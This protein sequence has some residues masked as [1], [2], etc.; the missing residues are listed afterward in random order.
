MPPRP[1]CVSVLYISKMLSA[2]LGFESRL[3]FF[4]SEEYLVPVAENLRTWWHKKATRIG[5]GR[6]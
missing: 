2:E 5:G 4:F 1:G 3:I 6:E